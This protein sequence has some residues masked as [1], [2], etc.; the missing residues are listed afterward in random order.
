MKMTAKLLVVLMSGLFASSY[1]MADVV[2]GTLTG[3]ALVQTATLSATTQGIVSSSNPTT[4]VSTIAPTTYQTVSLDVQNGNTK[5]KVYT[6]GDAPTA[7]VSGG[8][9]NAL[10]LT[11]QSASATS[12]IPVISSGFLAVIPTPAN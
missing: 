11:N 7:S 1:A 6:V 8:I 10:V 5:V 3:G 9:G 12:I 2:T 4:V